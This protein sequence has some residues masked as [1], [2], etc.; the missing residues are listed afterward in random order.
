MLLPNKHSSEILAI[1][2][3]SNGH[4]TLYP[5]NYANFNYLNWLD[6]AALNTPTYSPIRSPANSPA[7]SALG[8]SPLV[9]NHSPY[10]LF[11][12]R[13]PSE[14]L[15]FALAN[16]FS[17]IFALVPTHRYNRLFLNKNVSR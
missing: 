9:A 1:F 2:S 5:S 7:N 14:P 4:A 11:A 17:R 12:F 13:E 15:V 10:S 8:Y 3:Q 6:A 16:I